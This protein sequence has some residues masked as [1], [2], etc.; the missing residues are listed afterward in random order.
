MNLFHISL[1]KPCVAHAL[2]SSLF[3]SLISESIADTHQLHLRVSQGRQQSWVSAFRHTG[4]TT[5]R[6]GV[7]ACFR[8][9]FTSSQWG[10]IC[11]CRTTPVVGANLTSRWA[12]SC[13][14]FPLS[15]SLTLWLMDTDC[16]GITCEVTGQSEL[17]CRVHDFAYRC[18]FQQ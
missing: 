10:N 15:P 4:F 12:D 18:S 8:I 2:S 1:N 13:R 14:D 6:A 17:P 9:Q 7:R 5:I 3:L 11:D 16:C